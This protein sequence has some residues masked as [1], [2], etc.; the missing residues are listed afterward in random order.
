MELE[1]QF[2]LGPKF[3]CSTYSMGREGRRRSKEKEGKNQSSS[4]NK[5]AEGN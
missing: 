1:E 4:E 5:Q 2:D 3:G